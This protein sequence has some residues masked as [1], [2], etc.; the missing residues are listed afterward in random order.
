VL[1]HIG[2]GIPVYLWRIDNRNG[3]MKAAHKYPA[4]HGVAHYFRKHFHLT[5]SGNFDTAAL[6]NAISVMGADC[7]MFSVDWPFEDVGE[8]AR[9]IDTVEIDEADRVKVSRT[10]AIKLFKLPLR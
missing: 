4:K 8:G 2:E 6:V 9:W 7:V 10:N 5:T 1:G 3:W